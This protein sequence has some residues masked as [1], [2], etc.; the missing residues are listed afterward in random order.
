MQNYYGTFQQITA[1]CIR[2]ILFVISPPVSEPIQ[3]GDAYDLLVASNPG[4]D[5][6]QRLQH[7]NT[8]APTIITGREA[9]PQG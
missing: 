5:G 9:S 6:G 2:A 7:I 4:R 8:L 3:V 1:T